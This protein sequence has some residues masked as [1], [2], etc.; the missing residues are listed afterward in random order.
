MRFFMS[1]FI[2]VASMC[3][4]EYF[5]EYAFFQEP[6]CDLAKYAFGKRHFL[7]LVKYTIMFQ[8]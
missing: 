1:S 5:V 6:K 7:R 2:N 4:F 3:H 8:R